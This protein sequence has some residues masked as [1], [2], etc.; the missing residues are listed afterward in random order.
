MQCDYGYHIICLVHCLHFYYKVTIP[1]TMSFRFMSM[2]VYS[3]FWTK[4]LILAY[5][6]RVVGIVGINTI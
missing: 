6:E 3:L 1:L 4:V 2:V 5:V